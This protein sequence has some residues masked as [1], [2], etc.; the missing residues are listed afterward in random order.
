MSQR[1]SAWIPWLLA[2]F[3]APCPAARPNI[4][5]ILADDMGY[6]DVAALNPECKVRTPHLDQLAQAGM[7]FTDAH[8]TSAVCT[9]TRYGILT[10]RYNWR[11]SLQQGVCWGFSRRLIEPGRLTVAAFLREHGYATSAVGKWHLGMD[12]PTHSGGF[13]DDGRNWDRSYRGGWDVDFSRRIENGPLTVGFDTFFGISAS[14]DM[15]PYVYIRDDRPFVTKL[16]E[17][18]FFPGR[19]GPAD[20]DFRAIDV[21][22]RITDNAVESIRARAAAARDGRPFFLYFPLTAPHTPILPTAPW[23]GKSGINAYCDFVMQVDQCVG[24][25]AEALAAAEL[26]ESTLFIF[27]ADNGCSPQARFGE[28]AA[29]GHFPSY[30]FRGHKADIYEGGHRVPFIVRWPGQVVAGSRS[31]RLV[32]Q[33]DLFATL[34]EL[35]GQTVPV[36]AAGDSV[37]FLPTLTGG[38]QLPRS[39]VVHHS[40]NGSFAIREGRWKLELCP[41]SGGW[42]APR[43]RNA[44]GGDLPAVQLYDVEADSGEKRNLE[45]EHPDVVKRLTT[46]LESYVARGRST[47]GPE[48]KNTVPVNLWAVRNERQ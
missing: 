22:P 20:V 13:A 12:W 8:S 33:S 2:L 45:A 47:P 38:E 42:S 10:G 36:G 32:C 30:H 44:Y 18:E 23:R 48:Q 17:A 34:A 19:V 35:L 28:L 43:P 11:S 24:R 39:A 46:L 27:T 41:G 21:L 9:P 16:V 3:A 6:G 40:I 1:I 4:V 7:V 25:V 5:Y 29:K 26:T 31:D 14:L 15:P 37:S